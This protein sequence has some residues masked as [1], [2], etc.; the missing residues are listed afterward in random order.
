MQGSEDQGLWGHPPL[1]PQ[2]PA[3][4]WISSAA[5]GTQ[6]STSWDASTRGGRSAHYATALAYADFCI[7][8]VLCNFTKLA[9]VAFLGIFLDNFVSNLSSFFLP[10]LIALHETCST[11]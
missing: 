7:L 5:A 4:I 10:Y 2:A 1:L 9:L 11:Q 8:T 3:V 6:T